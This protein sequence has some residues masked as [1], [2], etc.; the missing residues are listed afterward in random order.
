MAACLQCFLRHRLGDDRIACGG[1]GND[2]VGL[3]ECVRQVGQRDRLAV[4]AFCQAARV[5]QRAIRDHQP[6]GAGF[7]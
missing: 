5:R 7:D 4:E 6:F 1:R 2:D 3:C